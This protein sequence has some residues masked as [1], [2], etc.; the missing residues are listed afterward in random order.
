M[1]ENKQ[2]NHRPNTLET[3]NLEIMRE[4]IVAKLVFTSIYFYVLAS[5]MVF[6]AQ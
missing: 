1:W 6:D 3:W 2:K 4:W 5:I